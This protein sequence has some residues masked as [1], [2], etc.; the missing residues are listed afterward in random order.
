MANSFRFIL[1]P[2]F[3]T[4]LVCSHYL[5]QVGRDVWRLQRSPLWLKK[6]GQLYSRRDSSLTEFSA[7][8]KRLNGRQGD[9]IRPSLES[10]LAIPPE[11]VSPE[12]RSAAPDPMDGL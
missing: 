3:L 11:G 1:T 6:I 9:G 12:R 8:Q 2:R 5:E 4:G 7:V 10:K